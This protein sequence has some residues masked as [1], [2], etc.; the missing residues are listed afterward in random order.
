MAIRLIS[1]LQDVTN[2]IYNAVCVY[3]GIAFVCTNEPK[4]R[5]WDLVTLAQGA[6]STTNPAS[7]PSGISIVSIVSGASAIAMI[8]SSGSNQYDFV[9][10]VTGARTQITTNATPTKYGY[11]NQQL[12]TMPTLGIACITQVASGGVKICNY[13][14]STVITVSVSG[15]ANASPSCVLTR[16]ASTN[17][18]FLVGTT[19]GSIKEI[20]SSGTLLATASLPLTPA[21][22]VQ[23]QIVTGLASWNDYVVAATDRGMLYCLDWTTG[24]VVDA[25]VAGAGT[26]NLSLSNSVSGTFIIPSGNQ[27]SSSGQ[28]LTEVWFDAGRFAVQDVFVEE[29]SF[30]SYGVAIDPSINRVIRLSTTATQRARVFAITPMNRVNVDT[31]IQ[32]P[33]GTDIEGR[34]I[35]IRDAGVGSAVIELDTTITPALTPLISTEDHNYIEIALSTSPSGSWDVREYKA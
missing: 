11:N 27:G 6:S 15:M 30:I 35:R 31:R 25:M 4:M 18:T 24:L 26:T 7:S 28:T 14:S 5:S 23:Q 21:T 17:N 2:S 34:I 13:N 9:H 33:L 1:E 20:T 22:G 19:D 8:V 16:S 32:Q 10:T 29:G 12:A 3:N